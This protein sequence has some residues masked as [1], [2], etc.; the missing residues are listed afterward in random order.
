MNTSEQIQALPPRLD[1]AGDARRICDVL[2]RGG[3]AIC[4]NTVGYGIW[5]GSKEGAQ[6]VFDTKQRGGHKRHALIAPF[7]PELP[8]MQKL[9]AESLKTRSQTSCA[10]C[11]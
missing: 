5:T 7:R 4:P 6:R 2:R 1:I 8:L 9:N 11:R 10:A 3:I